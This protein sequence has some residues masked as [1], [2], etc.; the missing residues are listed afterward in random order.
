MCYFFWIQPFQNSSFL[1]SNFTKSFHNLR[2]FCLCFLA[3]LCQ[4]V[5]LFHL[6][7]SFCFSI[8]P[9]SHLRVGKVRTKTRGRQWSR[10]SSVGVNRAQQLKN[11]SHQFAVTHSGRGSR[12]VK[13]SVEREERKWIIHLWIQAVSSPPDNRV[14]VCP[15]A[16]TGCTH[17]I[18]PAGT[19]APSSPTARHHANLKACCC[20]QLCFFFF[21]I[22]P[23]HDRY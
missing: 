6:A 20:F 10:A 22:F 9:P 8:C 11:S 5:I 18:C 13:E 16:P 19:N 3:H 23:F 12:G 7:Q 15:R 21:L 2:N 1:L 14:L 17:L 4:T